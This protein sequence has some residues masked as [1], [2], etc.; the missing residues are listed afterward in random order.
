[1]T[2][3]KHLNPLLELR[4]KLASSTKPLSSE[5][6][7]QLIGV[8]GGTLRNVE[9]GFRSFSPQLQ[10]QLRVRGLEWDE[11]AGRWFF[12]YDRD[13]PLS[14]WLL[15][16]F[17]RLSRGDKGFQRLD[18]NAAVERVK[19]L[20]ELVSDAKYKDLLLELNASLQELY[21]DFEITAAKEVF[22]RT[23][24]KFT[25]RKDPSGTETLIKSRSGATGL[26]DLN[27]LFPE[28]AQAPEPASEKDAA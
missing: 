13:A 25:Y 9:S 17:H 22:E 11:K 3:K 1:M 6:L 15:E 10:R 18:Q 12:T 28:G 16:T 8:S 19:A 21:E 27:E 5:R 23:A 20:L 26:A 7:G 14:L 4:C 24:L 2:A